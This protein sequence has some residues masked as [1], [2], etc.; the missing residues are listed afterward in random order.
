MDICRTTQLTDKFVVY[1]SYIL[2]LDY[3][4]NKNGPFVLKVDKNFPTLN[5]KIRDGNIFHPQSSA[6]LGSVNLN[7]RKQS[8]ITKEE[9]IEE[10]MSPVTTFNVPRNGDSARKIDT[11][12]MI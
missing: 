1:C 9:D 6:L 10:K 12:S 11:S 5:K 3:F 8:L 4:H 7:S 2:H